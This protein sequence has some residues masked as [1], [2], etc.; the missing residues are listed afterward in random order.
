MNVH[1][2]ELFYYVA[3]FG[4]I[5]AATRSMPYGIQQPS[6]SA[7][8]SRLEKE[9]G[10][11]LFLRRPFKLTAEG[12][13]LYQRILPFFS[14]LPDLANELRQEGAIQL[15]VAACSSVLRHHLPGLIQTMKTKKPGL[16]ITLEEVH[17]DEITDQLAKH[18]IDVSVGAVDGP[19]PATVRVDELIKIPLALLVTHDFP[20]ST[21]EEVLARS[22]RGDGR[23]ELP[24][25]SPPAQGVIAKRFQQGLSSVGAVWPHEVEV[26][27]FDL[28]PE[29]VKH[30]FGVGVSLVIPGVPPPDGLR[31]IE[32]TEFAPL[33]ILAVYRKDPKPA[34]AWFVKELKSLVAGLVP[35]RPRPAKASLP[36]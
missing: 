25:V 11:S 20:C 10:M 24:L 35:S 5:T 28:I 30:G 14:Q 31:Q 18:I 3:K 1:H 15:K 7:Q 2:L 17:W 9:L 6:L 33:P 22:Q 21:W 26:G 19:F 27:N 23:I 13:V 16:K 4:G 34:T 29:Y 8:I 36:A 32:I 12:E